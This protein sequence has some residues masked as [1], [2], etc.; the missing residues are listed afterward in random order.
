[1]VANS[2]E[3]IDRHKD[4]SFKAK[5]YTLH[6]ADG[7]LGVVPKRRHKNAVGLSKRQTDR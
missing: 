1:M 2:V 6:D 3:R 5:A 4:G 7:I